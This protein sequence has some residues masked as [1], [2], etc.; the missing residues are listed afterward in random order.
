[1]ANTGERSPQAQSDFSSTGANAID[2]NESTTASQTH[3]NTGAKI[4]F[5]S[6]F[7]GDDIPSGATINGIKVIFRG[8]YSISFADTKI[9]I[10]VSLDGASG[11]YSS[12]AAFQNLTTSAADY[13]F[14]G[15][16]ELWGLD[17]TDWTDLSDLAIKITS[18]QQNASDT[19]AIT[20]INEVDAII[21][22]TEVVSPKS[23]VEIKGTLKVLG[24][25]VTIK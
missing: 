24:G 17:W 16:D 25:Q 3:F 11:T 14:G 18:D 23:R 21:Y 15:D 6:D 1:M 9:T 4:G 8:S 7:D 20:F 5:V 12:N 13:N 10:G 2:S 22:Y 19:T